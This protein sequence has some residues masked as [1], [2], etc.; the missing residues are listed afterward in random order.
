MTGFDTMSEDEDEELAMLRLQALMSKR[1]A[2]TSTSKSLPFPV[3]LALVPEVPK[4]PV[5]TEEPV[6][7]VPVVVTSVPAAVPDP[8]QGVNNN[9]GSYRQPRFVHGQASHCSNW[10]S[11]LTIHHAACC[12]HTCCH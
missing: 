8:P 4:A 7:T 1:R 3:S 11:F 6:T 5:T 9:T 12:L 10:N 2:G